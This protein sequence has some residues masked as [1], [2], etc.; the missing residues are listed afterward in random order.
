MGQNVFASGK[1]VVAKGDGLEA[2][3]QDGRQFLRSLKRKRINNQSLATI[4]NLTGLTPH[5]TLTPTLT[6]ILT[7]TLISILEPSRKLPLVHLF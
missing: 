2:G 5:L 4:L 7:Q 3:F 6:L 1:M